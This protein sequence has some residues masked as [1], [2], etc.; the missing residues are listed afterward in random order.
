MQEHQVPVQ[1]LILFAY[2]TKQGQASDAQGLSCT[3][4]VHVALRLEQC[5]WV[6]ENVHES[7]K[8]MHTV[9]LKIGVPF[10]P[11]LL[12]FPLVIFFNG[13]FPVLVSFCIFPTFFC[14]SLQ[15]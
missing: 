5:I 2:Y 4:G 14:I 15:P 6:R 13:P 7:G 1:G 8:A 11:F 9:K 3:V 10:L 12:T